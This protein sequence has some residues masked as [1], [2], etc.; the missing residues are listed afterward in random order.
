M[1]H[2]ASRNLLDE[3]NINAPHVTEV[4][5]LLQTLTRQD[6]GQGKKVY[7]M[8]SAGRGEG[9]STV[10]AL[11]AIIA[12][13]IFHR[14]TLVIDGDMR[15]PTLHYLLGLPQRPGLY[16][17]LHGIQPLDV[18]TRNTPISN[19][20]AIT[21]GRPTGSAGEAYIDSEFEALVES[22]RPKYDIIFID[23]APVVPVVEPLLMAEHVDSVLVVAM[24]GRTPLML[25]RRMRQLIEPILA[26]VSGVV[27]NNAVEGLPYYYDYRYY[28]YGEQPLPKRIR[29]TAR[30]AG[31][32]PSSSEDHYV[33][34]GG[35]DGRHE[36]D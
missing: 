33:R 22:V 6:A 28:G 11:L 26:K 10:C 18:V 2:P 3:F 35:M 9:K 30:S 29:T 32:S 1:P 27:L 25:V 20:H 19:L 15:R 14:R 23:A 21:S 5:R 13:K 12:A 4:R 17:A 36:S 16:D 34:E 7:M 8:A 31:P 24:A